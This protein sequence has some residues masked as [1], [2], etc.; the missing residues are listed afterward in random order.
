MA[1]RAYWKGYLKLSLVSC[2]IALYPAASSSERVSFNRVNKKTGNRLK[3]QLVDAESGEPVDKEDIGRGYEIGKG[4][5]L[6]VAD[7]EIEK[8]QI[9][10]T[11]TIEIDS[12]VPRAEIDDRYIDSPYYIAP[13]DQVGQEA[14]AVIR[15][16]IR[17]K[18]M[19]AL[20]R[21]MVARREHVVM[22]EAL[23][24]GLL[25]TT[26]RYPYEVRDPAAYFE[27]IPDLKLPDEM[28]QLAA[29]IVDSKAAHFDP[30]KF[31][32]HYETALV[33]L[34]RAKQAG[35]VVEAPKDQPAP[36]RVINLMDAL[37][38]SIGADT[39]KKP[40]AES[41]KVRARGTAA[42]RKTGR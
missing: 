32:D 41:T 17:E 38:A 33:D 37:R 24:K 22:L 21:V 10:S 29:H 36:D 8:I 27:D 19:V 28:R 11:R 2:P 9:P 4:Q 14:F 26:L 15:D 35:H 40:P 6:Q 31:V 18:K 12:F 3:Q 13:T 5:Y 34:L 23:D 1:P 30:S 7:E 39:K 16:A 20:G 25:A 42:K